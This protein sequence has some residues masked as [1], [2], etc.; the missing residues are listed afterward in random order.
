MA[1]NRLSNANFYFDGTIAA[2]VFTTLPY[3]GLLGQ[4]FDKDGKKYQLVQLAAGSTSPA[5]AGAAAFWDGTN[6]A[7]FVINNDISDDSVRGRNL[8]AGVILGAPTASQYCFIQVRGVHDAI[9][10][11]GDDDITLGMTLVLDGTVDGAVDSVAA[12][13]AS[14]Y[15]PFGIA[16]A[17]DVDLSNT[18]QGLITVPLNGE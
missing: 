4:F 18:V 2:S 5:T 17:S 1:S 14:T 6:I 13:T 8:P 15:V 11:N 16:M 7:T 10:T 12:G 3:P 9:V